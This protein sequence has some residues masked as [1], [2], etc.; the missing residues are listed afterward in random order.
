MSEEIDWVDELFSTPLP[1]VPNVN[2]NTQT[3]LLN[4]LRNSTIDAE[5]ED[6]I[7]D[8]IVKGEFTIE[9]MEQLISK[10][11]MNQIH[12]TN[13]PNPSQ[14]QISKFIQNISKND[15]P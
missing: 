9:S 10:L 5:E 12:F 13:I 7:E 2:W 11:K 4:L 1:G 3:W 6:E 15:N 8:Q 14:K